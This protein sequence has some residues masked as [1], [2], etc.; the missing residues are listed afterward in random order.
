VVLVRPEDVEV[1]EAD[2]PPEPA[3][4]LRQEVEKVLR[5]AVGIERAQPGEILVRSSMPALPSP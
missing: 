4:A 2:D 5:I 1:L 3:L